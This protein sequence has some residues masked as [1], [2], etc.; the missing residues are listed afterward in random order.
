[1]VW[2]AFPSSIISTRDSCLRITGGWLG[3]ALP[4]AAFEHAATQRPCIF[5]R[6]FWSHNH[7]ADIATVPRVKCN[8]VFM[9]FFKVLRTHHTNSLCCC[10]HCPQQTLL[11]GY[12]YTIHPDHL[13]SHSHSLLTPSNSS[14]SAFTDQGKATNTRGWLRCPKQETGD[15]RGEKFPLL[16]TGAR[17]TSPLGSPEAQ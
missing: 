5:F 9:G 10:Q 4:S 14:A 12:V 6:G 17:K 3:Q 13:L 15:E 16:L 7:Y 8:S 2:S 1:M 11:L